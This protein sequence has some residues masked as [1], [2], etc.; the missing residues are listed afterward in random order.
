MSLLILP[1]RSHRNVNYVEKMNSPPVSKR[2]ESCVTITAF[3]YWNEMVPSYFNGMST[4]SHNSYNTRSQ[5]VFNIPLRKTN[6][7]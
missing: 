1:P 2:V 3:I 6:T 4:P 5:M 7:G